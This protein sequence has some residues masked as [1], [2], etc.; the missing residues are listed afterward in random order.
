MRLASIVLLV[1]L[2]GCSERSERGAEVASAP[3]DQ[4]GS[5]AA[6]GTLE[7]TSSHPNV[8][9]VEAS[10]LASAEGSETDS[11]APGPSDSSTATGA[12][13]EGVV[14][15]ADAALDRRLRETSWV[16]D[17]AATLA[18]DLN[19]SAVREQL[20]MLAWTRKVAEESIR[21][22]GAG[23]RHRQKFLAEETSSFYLPERTRLID[24]DHVAIQE[25]P[26]IWLVYR[27]ADAE[28]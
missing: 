25:D 17:E 19:A 5:G 11:I 16:F 8:G 7:E 28:N 12:G 13:E 14:S 21:R 9:Q 27:A 6:P 10:G 1:A 18:S 15:D 3:V 26:G 22:E 24:R 4:V 2:S 23:W 20:E